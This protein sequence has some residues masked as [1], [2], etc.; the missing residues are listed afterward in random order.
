M[1]NGK[2]GFNSLMEEAGSEVLVDEENGVLIS[3]ILHQ[4][5]LSLKVLGKWT[6]GAAV[7]KF[8]GGLTSDMKAMGEVMPCSQTDSSFKAEANSPESDDEGGEVD[9]PEK[10]DSQE[11]KDVRVM[12]LVKKIGRKWTRLA[13]LRHQGEE[14]FAVDWTQ[15]IAPRLE[16]R[17]KIV[18]KA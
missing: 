15:S 6:R 13:G 17:I 18:T 14:E 2:D 3:M 5:F 7:R 12:E 4:Y 16:G 10:K 9:L 11:K 1:V 8:F